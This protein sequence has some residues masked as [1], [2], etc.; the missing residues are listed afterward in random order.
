MPVDMKKLIAEAVHTL[1]IE[2]KVKKLT[3]KDIVEECHI[4][5]Q[6]FYY[7]F[8]D[9]PDLLR[10]ILEQSKEE[11]MREARNQ[12]EAESALR[13]FFLMAINA[14]PYIKKTVQSNYGDEIERLM[15][16]QTYRLF[17]QLIEENNLYQGCSRFEL[18]LIIRYHSQ[19]II[20]ILREWTEED[21]KNLDQI[22][23][24]VYLLMTGG[25][26]PTKT[27]DVEK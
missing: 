8:E 10:W 19:A 23:H 20:G 16:Q 24:G 21:T 3:V 13:Y 5:R 15:E 14:L 9:I 11:F 7:H 22:V 4:T 26:S 12:K 17:E 1:L 27:A 25:I 2:K 18:K 6:S